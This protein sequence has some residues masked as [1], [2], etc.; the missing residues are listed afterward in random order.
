MPYMQIKYRNRQQQN[1][2]YVLL[3]TERRFYDH[4]TQ[5]CNYHISSILPKKFF[6]YGVSAK[7]RSGLS[8]CLHVIE[9]Y[10][11]GFLRCVISNLKLCWAVR[12]LWKKVGR[13]CHYW[14]LY[15]YTTIYIYIYIY[16]YCNLKCKICVTACFANQNWFSDGDDFWRLLSTGM[17]R[18]ADW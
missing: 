2:L 18:H 7:L 12:K 14:L 5:C 17:R 4:C 6:K 10:T 15:A 8:D 1:H 16:I 3:I 11:D 9:F 13:I